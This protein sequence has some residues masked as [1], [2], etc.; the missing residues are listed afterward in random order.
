MAWESWRRNIMILRVQCLNGIKT[1]SSDP[2]SGQLAATGSA[3]GFQE[4]AVHHVCRLSGG[5]H[6]LVLHGQLLP[7]TERQNWQAET[8]SSALPSLLR[9]TS[10]RED[11]IDQFQNSDPRLIFRSLRDRMVYSVLSG[12]SR[13]PSVVVRLCCLHN[14]V[15]RVPL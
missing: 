9:S 4:E 11:N 14:W 13:H 8:G 15:Q 1:E 2:L 12:V 5:E 10:S 7:Q 6:P 3:G